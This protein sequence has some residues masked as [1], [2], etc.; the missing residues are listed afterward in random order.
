MSLSSSGKS[1]CFASTKPWVP[2]PVTTREKKK[3]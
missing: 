2:T 1:A 3:N